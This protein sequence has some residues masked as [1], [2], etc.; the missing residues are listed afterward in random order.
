MDKEKL[1]SAKPPLFILYDGVCNFCI[2]IVGF[3]LR[4]DTSKSLQA[5]SIQSKEGRTILRLNNEKFISLKTVY[6]IDEKQ[7]YK[8]STAIFKLFSRLPFP[9]KIIS[10]FQILPVLFTDSVYG[11]IAR[12]RYTLFGKQEVVQAE[13][14][15]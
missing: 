2:S 3:A 5:V 14:R 1:I 11:I 9:W 12:Y 7:V 4:I 8:K 15:K 13:A 10:W 6:F